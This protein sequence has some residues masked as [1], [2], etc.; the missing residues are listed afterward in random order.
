MAT[1]IY[2][3][4]VQICS[5]HRFFWMLPSFCIYYCSK[6]YNNFVVVSQ[7]L[8]SISLRSPSVTTIRT[9]RFYLSYLCLL[10]CPTSCSFLHLFRVKGVL[11]FSPPPPSYLESSYSSKCC[12]ANSSNFSVSGCSFSACTFVVL[13]FF[14]A[15]LA[16]TSFLFCS[17]KACATF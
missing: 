15:A 1:N 11:C 10:C 2:L 12:K 3:D 9:M 16:T 7:T 8:S 6:C 14:V 17:T 5:L 13:S 4:Q